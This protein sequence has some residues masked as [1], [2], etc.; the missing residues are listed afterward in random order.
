MDNA[1]YD[2]TAVIV[3]QGSSVGVGRAKGR[4]LCM[5]DSLIRTI[6]LT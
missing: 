6:I 4:R 2:L 1:L 3:H 5:E